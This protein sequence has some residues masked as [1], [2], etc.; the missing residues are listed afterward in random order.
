LSPKTW[1]D[2]NKKIEDT[3]QK[4]DDV[5]ENPETE[6]ISQEL[7]DIAKKYKGIAFRKGKPTKQFTSWLNDQNKIN[8]NKIGE[9]KPEEKTKTTTIT[10][11]K[12]TW[13]DE[14]EKK[15]RG[16]DKSFQSTLKDLR[17]DL[18]DYI[19]SLKEDKKELRNK[20]KES[21][22]SGFIVLLYG[23]PGIGKSVFCASGVI[24]NYLTVFLDIT[25]QGRR[26]KQFKEIYKSDLFHYE[27]FFER[28]EDGNPDSSK[29]FEKID[30][31]VAHALKNYN[32]ETT[33]VIIDGFSSIINKLNAYLRI[34]ILKIGD[35]KRG[36]QTDISYG[37]WYWRK[38]RY[39][40]LLSNLEAA[41]NEGFKIFLTAEVVNV[42]DVSTVKGKLKITKTGE[43]APKASDMDLFAVDVEGYFRNN[44][45]PET[46]KIGPRELEIKSSKIPGIIEGTVLVRPD[47]KTFIELSEKTSTRKLNFG[48]KK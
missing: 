24:D 14:I 47:M 2:E 25:N 13:K 10:P 34:D 28:T 7:K 32:P 17:E 36:R 19:I 33:V 43:R 29:I 12:K 44:Y 46:D 35:P 6:L 39:N 20:L 31:Y 41:A 9:K 16:D 23:I 5:I 38:F 1:K 48:E 45:D 42:V 40:R 15:S 21:K 37:D 22:K 27:P 11:K 8:S 18:A 3:L 26:L 30:S 4:P